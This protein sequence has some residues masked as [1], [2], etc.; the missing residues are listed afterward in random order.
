M[1]PDSIARP[2]LH[3]LLEEAVRIL[4]QP[5]FSLRVAGNFPILIEFA[6]K[7]VAL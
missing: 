3:E 5:G 6:G 2:N 4:D 7:F 1:R